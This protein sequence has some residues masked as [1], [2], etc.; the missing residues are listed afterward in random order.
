MEE[1]GDCL[2]ATLL[3]R[4]DGQTAFTLED[5]FSSVQGRYCRF[6]K[7][8]SQGPRQEGAENLPVIALQET[9][10]YS[11]SLE[12][13]GRGLLCWGWH[14]EEYFPPPT[15]PTPLRWSRAERCTV[16]W[17]LRPWESS[18]GS[19]GQNLHRTQ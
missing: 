17:V 11:L 1:E 9:H 4:T 5:D 13:Y 18:G 8:A 2:E 6:G 19:K 15:P 3:H 12:R 10:K 16:V 14:R 7:S